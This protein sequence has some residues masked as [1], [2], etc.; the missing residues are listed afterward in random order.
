[1][2]PS[3]VSGA[4][5]IVAIAIW[6]YLLFGRGVFWRISNAM[7]P[8]AKEEVAAKIVAVI[9]ARNEA[10]VITTCLSSVLEVNP[11]LIA[12]IF[13]V[14]DGSSDGTAQVA[15]RTAA[16]MNAG[17]K[18][19]VI[20]S[21][22]LPE[23]WTGKL[24]AMQ[25][26]IERALTLAPEFLLLTDA[27]VAHATA[28][29]ASLIQTARKNGYDL[30]SLMVRLQCRTF[31]EKLLIPAFVFFFF[32]LYPP[33]WCPDSRRSSAGAAGGCILVR[34]AALARAGGLEA[35]K[36]EIIDD[37]ALARA[38][39]R[40]GGKLWIGLAKESH[41]ERAYGSF[42]ET[43]KM[44]SRSAFNQL[45]HS[46]W[47]LAGAIVGMILT[48]CLPAALLISPGAFAKVC[49][50]FALAAM[51]FAYS[52]MI[53]FY[54]LNRLWA[55]TLPFAAV[56]YTAATVHSAISYWRGRGGEWKGRH[57]DQSRR[58]ATA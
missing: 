35:I 7:L 18:L 13:L 41:S 11:R 52:P 53:R 10:D 8:V 20:E 4:A 14:D 9:P 30:A 28:D 15:A 51:V 23:G 40:S 6:F 38:V 43:G 32:K 50:F 1:M 57:Q 47:V 54:R 46:A 56:F 45:G 22:P 44:I 55:L 19:T 42:A 49:A 34:P 58:R 5:G 12:H 37:C 39:K 27:D 48:Y 25:Q 36:G 26:G 24:W 31:A 33:S 17:S 16:S 3:R 21:A 2:D 29:I